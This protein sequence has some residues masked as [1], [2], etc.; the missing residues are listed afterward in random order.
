MKLA[1]HTRQGRKP[2]LKLCTLPRNTAYFKNI[3]KHAFNKFHL[4]K[5]FVIYI[6]E[7]IVESPIFTW[8]KLF[9]ISFTKINEFKITLPNKHSISIC[10]LIHE[11]I[12]VWIYTCICKYLYSYTNIYIHICEHHSRNNHKICVHFGQLSEWK[13]AV[14]SY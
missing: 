6:F 12:N 4:T 13:T 7:T 3:S 11:N 10:I 1:D 9:F 5:I 8:R 2:L 14:I